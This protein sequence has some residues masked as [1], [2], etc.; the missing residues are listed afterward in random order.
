VIQARPELGTTSIVVDGIRGSRSPFEQY[1]ALK[2]AGA[3][4]D[5]PR[6]GERDQLRA[7]LAEARADGTIRGPGSPGEILVEYL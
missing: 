5:Q 6:E 2:A 1:Q 4:I 7:A 3:I